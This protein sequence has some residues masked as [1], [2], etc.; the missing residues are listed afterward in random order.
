M[1]N[2]S[3]KAVSTNEL[4][5]ELNQIRER[6]TELAG[7]SQRSEMLALLERQHHLVQQMQQH[8]VQGNRSGRNRV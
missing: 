8:V 7:T 1:A 2:E 3:T 5:A 4:V 6:L